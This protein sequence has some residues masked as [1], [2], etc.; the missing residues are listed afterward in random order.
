M[1]IPCNY[2]I[3]VATQ[4]EK[5]AAYGRHY[6]RIELGDCSLKIAKEKFK[7]LNEK[8]GDEFRLTLTEVYCGSREI[9]GYC[10][11]NKGMEW[12]N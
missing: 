12:R 10:Y 5:N 4:P 1:T 3:N 2:E 11:T 8:L 7:K 6:C 9:S